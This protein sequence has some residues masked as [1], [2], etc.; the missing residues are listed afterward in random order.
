[1]STREGPQLS[2]L[3]PLDETARAPRVKTSVIKLWA[4][5]CPSNGSRTICRN[6]RD[7]V[8]AIRFFPPFGTS[9]VGF[10]RGRTMANPRRMT[11]AIPRGPLPRAKPMDF[12]ASPQCED[13][14]ARATNRP[15]RVC[16]SRWA[17][18]NL[19]GER[20]RTL[21]PSTNRAVTLTSGGSRG[22]YETRLALAGPATRSDDLSSSARLGWRQG[23]ACSASCRGAANTRPSCRPTRSVRCRRTVRIWPN[24]STR[25][26]ATRITSAPWTRPASSCANIIPG[27]G[28]ESQVFDH[29]ANGAAIDLRSMQSEPRLGRVVTRAALP[30]DLPQE[31]GATERFG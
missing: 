15:A 29:L 30:Q 27:D 13:H 4:G 11:F 10:H 7:F 6:A 20:V 21:R 16:Q 17:R 18:A 26:E 31:L 14:G 25:I 3:A 12:M 22:R 24:V 19:A 8:R 23:R 2:R 5:L 1:M 28:G 9:G